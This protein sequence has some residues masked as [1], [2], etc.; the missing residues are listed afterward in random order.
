VAPAALFGVL[1]NFAYAEAL[2]ITMHKPR[3]LLFLLCLF[4]ALVPLAKPGWSQTDR[5]PVKWTATLEP[6]DLRAGETGRVLLEAKIKAPWHIYAPTTPP[7]GPIAT[8][9]QL[10]PSPVAK[11][12][13]K[14]I[15][16][17][18][19]SHLDP[20]FGIQVQT[21]D[22]GVTF[23]LPVKIDAK[24]SGAKTF[25]LSVR[26]QACND[27]LCLP[28]KTVEVPVAA[29][30]ASGAVRPDHQKADTNIPAQA[31]GGGAVATSGGATVAATSN[32][33]FKGEIV[34]AGSGNNPSGLGAF[35]LVAFLSGFASLLTP[36]VFP[37]IPITVS[38]FT[39][40]NEKAP[41]G[42]RGPIAYCLGIVATFTLIGVVVS[43]VVGAA[44]IPLLAANPWLNLGMAV[45]FV[46]LA[47]NLFGAYEIIVPSAL[48]SKVQPTGRTGLA[49]P[50][51]MGFAFSLTS[52]TCTVPFV[53]TT[54][55]SA[56][57]GGVLRP[58]L[59][60]MAFSSAFALPFFLLALF[61]S[62]LSKL[63]RA[64]E[65]LVSVKAYMG[66]LELAAA[67]KFVQQAD[68]TWQL[69]WLTRPVFLS[70]WFAIAIMAGLYLLR[71]IRLPKDSPN[72]KIGPLRRGI[73]VGTL[74]V[75]LILL[76]ANNG[77]S[78]RDFDAYLPPAS[79][80]AKNVGETRWLKDDFEAAMRQAK[81]ENKPILVNFT[82]YA[83]TNC[84]LMEEHVLPTPAVTSELGGFVPVFLHTDGPDANSKKYSKLQQEKLQTVAIPVYA[85]MTPDGQ[86]KGT[87]EGLERDPDKFVE[88][89]RKSRES[90]R[91]ASNGTESAV[92]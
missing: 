26:F 16:P 49:A 33:N 12:A 67:L 2:I 77:L 24:A 87:L 3:L 11:A 42:L 6:A 9:V 13:G 66:F 40:Q 57:T 20:G 62:F 36:C 48:L 58:A 72:L 31:G 32:L 85:V 25:K 65:W 14:L 80:G 35:L 61:P 78:L 59:G 50:L 86:V 39:K 21:Y 71:W 19:L 22:K 51:L 60:M 1:G 88:F 54:L 84:R 81:A 90:V 8:S 23:A 28:P 55:V 83:C 18:P 15:Q 7:G 5:D 44:G 46:L 82:G 73:A 56:S 63:P 4:S 70:V 64:G 17:K 53:G 43:A 10:V 74:A 52:F 30:I 45:L 75:A 37:M 69:G 91:L 92:Q 89:L 79:Y 76:G 41:T 29:K 38:L 27:R 34:R 47:L 68:Y